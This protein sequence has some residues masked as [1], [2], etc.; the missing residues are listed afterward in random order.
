MELKDFVSQSLIQITEGV[1]SAQKELGS[2]GAKINP[3][4]MRLLKGST[5]GYGS[6]GWPKDEGAN[7]VLLVDFDVAV[8]AEEGKHT[9]GGIGVVAG[10]FALG[11]QAKSDAVNSSISRIRFR[12]PLLL[13]LHKNATVA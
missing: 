5:E 2:R 1:I 12:V 7:P 13:P 11:S 3:E 9:K 6:F 4:M 10:V 8:T